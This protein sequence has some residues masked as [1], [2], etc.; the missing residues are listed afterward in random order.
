MEFQVSAIVGDAARAVLARRLVV[1][2]TGEEKKAG[3][4]Q[5]ERP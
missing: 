1:L 5:F 3:T 2:Q 4:V